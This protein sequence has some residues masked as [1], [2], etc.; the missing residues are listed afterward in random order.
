MRTYFR[1]TDNKL[2]HYVFEENVFIRYHIGKMVFIHK[3]NWIIQNII[4]DESVPEKRTIILKEM[5]TYE[6]GVAHFY[7]RHKKM[8]G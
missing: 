8:Q 4:I 2:Q 7:T 5:P 1:D 3:K 6:A